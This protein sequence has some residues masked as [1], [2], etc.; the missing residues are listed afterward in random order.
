MRA[1]AALAMSVLIPAAARASPDPAAPTVPAPEVA[2]APPPPPRRADVPAE[3]ARSP[4]EL[5]AR[6]PNGGRGL[7]MHNALTVPRGAVDV[8]MRGAMPLGG[9]VAIAAGLGE[10]T[11]LSAEAGIA[12]E[13]SDAAAVVGVGFKQVIA[14]AR[15][16]QLSVG[17]SLRHLRDGGADMSLGQ[18]GGTLT[19]C[20]DTGCGLMMSL[21]LSGLYV[22][23]E[24]DVRVVV[25][26]G[27]SAGSRHRRFIG[28]VVVVAG[29][30]LVLGGMRIGGAR[31]AADVG[32]ASAITSGADVMPFVGFAA[33]L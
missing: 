26:A 24:D 15:L 3:P 22:R 23:E 17:G 4:L 20:T 16:V 28:E 21:G 8:S 27:F 5:R 18:L 12:H 31:Y 32:I 29:T 30:E 25:S 13:N 19:V 11:E 14:S 10:R 7:A 1:A 9:L 2:P 33:R 6:V